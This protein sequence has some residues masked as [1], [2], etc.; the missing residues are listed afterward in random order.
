MRQLSLL[1]TSQKMLIGF[2][3]PLLESDNAGLKSAVCIAVGEM[4][5]VTAL[6]LPPGEEKDAKEG[7]E[8]TKLAMVNKLIG[9]IKTTKETNKVCVLREGGEDKRRN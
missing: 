8:V 1:K 7:G 6:L 4:A 9:M 5:K 2:A 3:D